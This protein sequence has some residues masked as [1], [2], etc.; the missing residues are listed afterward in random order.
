VVEQALRNGAN[1]DTMLNTI[2][3]NRWGLPEEIAQVCVFLTSTR[4]SLMT[5][6]EV[7]VDGGMVNA[8]S[9]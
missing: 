2:P 1:Y 7:L 5:G 9:M 6:E 4:A 8:T 3:I